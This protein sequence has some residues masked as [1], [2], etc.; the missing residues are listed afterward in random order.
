MA[1]M[2]AAPNGKPQPKRKGKAG[3]PVQWLIHR[4]LGGGALAI[5]PR[6]VGAFCNVGRFIGG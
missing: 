3:V 5:L 6:P 2:M 4:G 1:G